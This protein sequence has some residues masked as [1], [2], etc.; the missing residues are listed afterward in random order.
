[1]RLPHVYGATDLFFARVQRG[2]V[3]VPGRT[4]PLYA[5]LHV[6]DAARALIAAAERGWQGAAALGDREPVGWDDFLGALQQQLPDLRIVRVP[7]AL[8]LAGTRALAVAFAASSAP[9]L[10]TPD[11]VVSWNLSLPV[12]PH[13]VWPELGIDPLLPTYRE[14]IA[15]TLDDCVAFRWRH[16][17]ADRR[18]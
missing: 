9:R 15:R 5:H 10:Q 8:A 14:G 2:L 4:D 12:D 13:A 3:I 6:S 18:R 11:A 16:P 7:E 17:V 1:L